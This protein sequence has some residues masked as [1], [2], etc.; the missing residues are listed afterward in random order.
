M[1]IKIFCEHT[2]LSQKLNCLIYNEF[3]HLIFFKCF[4]WQKNML[5][6]D[7][8]GYINHH[9]HG[10][11]INLHIYSQVQWQ[12]QWSSWLRE[13]VQTHT[14]ATGGAPQAGSGDNLVCKIVLFKS[15]VPKELLLSVICIPRRPLVSHLFHKMS[16]C[17]LSVPVRSSCPWSVPYEFL[18]FVIF[19]PR[20]RFVSH[21]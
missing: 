16:S 18:F 7:Y 5:C 14:C 6:Y 17:Q 9:H 10:H 15:A 8:Q 19:N 11:H 3:F 20:G 13:M 1:V 4:K 21:L 12:N 2:I